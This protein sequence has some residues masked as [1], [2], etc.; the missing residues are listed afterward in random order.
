MKGKKANPEFVSSFIQQCAHQGI[1]TPEAILQEAKDQIEQID[2]E[3][4]DVINKKAL[5]SKLCDVVEK[6]GSPKDKSEDIRQ[7]Q[8]FERQREKKPQ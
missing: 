3:I 4:K 2:Q 5:R 8:L 7:L 1:Q 6:F